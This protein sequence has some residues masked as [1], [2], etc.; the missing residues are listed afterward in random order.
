MMMLAPNLTVLVG[1]LVGAKL[2]AAAGS[3]VNLAK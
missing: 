3:L 2:I 1:D